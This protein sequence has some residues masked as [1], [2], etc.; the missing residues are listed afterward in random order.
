MR[1]VNKRDSP[2]FIWIIIAI[3]GILLAAIGKQGSDVQGAGLVV[4]L[5]SV[6]IIY[7]IV[8]RPPQ[9]HLSTPLPYVPATKTIPEDKNR[10]PQQFQDLY[11][12]T[13][14]NGAAFGVN[15][16]DTHINFTRAYAHQMKAE[17]VHNLP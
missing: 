14:N 10:T 13:M 12:F 3:V 9:F 6:A 5:F 4:L 16:A 15:P 7:Y 8:L 1:P 11:T 2:F 17:G